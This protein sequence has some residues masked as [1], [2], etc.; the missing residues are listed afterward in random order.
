VGLFMVL[1]PFAM[2]F[3]DV[4]PMAWTAWIIGAISIVI[5]VAD[6][7]WTHVHGKGW[8]SQVH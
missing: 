3:S 1:S 4:R 7:R 2:R 5:G 6:V 8:T